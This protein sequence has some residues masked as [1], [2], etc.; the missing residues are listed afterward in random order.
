MLKLADAI[1]LLGADDKALS[2]DL[3]SA[4]GKTKSWASG[5]GSAIKGALG[6][7]LVAGAAAVSTAVVGIGAAAFSTASQV[8]AS[9]KKIQSQLN[10][11]DEAA[12]Q[13]G[14]SLRNVYANNFGDSIADVAQS[15]TDVEAAFR[16]IGGTESFGQLEKATSDAIALRDA[17][18]VSVVESTEAAV[19]LMDKFG[20]TSQQAFDFLATGFQQGL[21]A[22]DDFLDSITEYSTQFANG[23]ADATQFFSLLQSGLQAGALGTDKAA[24]A[25]KEFR[26]RIND[27]STLTAKSLEAL[28]INVEAFTA[29]LANGSLSTAD[30]F[31]II[32]DKLRT[33]ED[34]TLRMQAAVG[35]IGTQ[36]EDLGDSAVLNLSLAKFAVEDFSGATEALNRQYETLP[37]LF[38]GLRRRFLIAIEP[39]GG[40]MLDAFNTVMPGII[41]LFDGLEARVKEFVAASAFTWDPDFKQVKL[42]DLFAW[43]KE[44]SG[45]SAVTKINIGDWFEFTGFGN[46]KQIRLGDLFEFTSDSAATTI[47]LA[48]YLTIAFNRNGTYEINVGDLFTVTNDGVQTSID[49]ADYIVIEYDSEPR[50][51]KV[52][53]LFELDRTGPKQLVTVFDWLT[54]ETTPEGGPVLVD[55]SKLFTWDFT[56]VRRLTLGDFIPFVGSATKAT[57]FLSDYLDFDI[58]GFKQI[59]IS[60]LF[61]FV[62][63]GDA[64]AP[65]DLAPFFK[66]DPASF[67]RVEIG[68]IFPFLGDNV[69]IRLSDYLEIGADYPVFDI[70]DFMPFLDEGGTFDLAKILVVGE[71]GFDLGASLAE[72]A[73]ALSKALGAPDWFTDLQAYTWPDLKESTRTTINTLIAWVWPDLP[74]TLDDLFAWAW[75][76]AP[77]DI[78][79][80]LSWVWP[81]FGAG[82]INAINTITS[83]Q[84]PELERPEWIDQLLNFSIPA[85]AWVTNLLNWRP[86]LPAWLGGSS[87]PNSG[88]APFAPT[89]VPTN[90]NRGRNF[91]GDAGAAVTVNIYNPVINNQ[92]DIDALARQIGKR[93]AHAA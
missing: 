89:P 65:T 2:S 83:F 84:W 29:K 82:V 16:R 80:L 4:E 81:E 26:L 18:G 40:L 15:L 33:I 70:R 28:G 92:G 62:G 3:K 69:K 64:S 44:G 46:A 43:V 8:E 6:G 63:D 73:T 56:M 76:D 5:L 38:E 60:D 79:S 21:N 54:V 19:E 37:T 20:L 24:D 32:L 51:I 34:P 45:D 77:T 75:P 30:A 13:F 91:A 36:F 49:L 12:Q 27:G 57:Y 74:T 71:G 11:T 68:D 50:R 42:G 48:D 7:A 23:G 59:G 90:G 85:P 10:L 52:G 86:S 87:A 58:S 55:V 61:S 14:D 93:I 25:F 47:N 1:L 88:E 78:S 22:S 31:Q 67:G 39:L 41:A 72:A 35:L 53:S 17:F 66:W 9:T